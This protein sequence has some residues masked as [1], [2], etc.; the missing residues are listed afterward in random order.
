MNLAIW[1]E[2]IA[3]RYTD[4]EA[5]F[6]GTKCIGTYMDLWRVAC[7]L[8]RQLEKAGVKLG[9]RVAVLMHNCPEYL[10]AFYGVWSMGAVILPINSKLHSKEVK[11]IL[12][13]A[14]CSV[15]LTNELHAFELKSP[16]LTI[17]IPKWD[18]L[19]GKA[20]YSPITR[21]SDDLAWLFYTSGTTGRP[22]GVMITHGMIK[23]M[24][25]SY[26]TDVDQ[27][28]SND[29]ALY[30]APMSHGAGLY[31]VMH[32]LAGARHAMPLSG[33]FD[34]KEIF[35]LAKRLKSIHL[36]AA[37]TM[38]KRL[39]NFAKIN[40]L[41]GRGIRTIVYAGGPM[42]LLDII[43]ATEKFGP[44]FIQ[45][46]GQG[47]CPMGIT[48]LPRSKV[49]DR[50]SEKWKDRLQSVGFAQSGIEIK[51]GNKLGN[52][53]KNGEIG[54]IMVRGELVMPGYWDNEEATSKTIING[55]LMT[56]DMGTIDEDG[57]LTMHGRSND[58]IISGGSNIY[59]R[60]VEEV[61]LLHNSVHEVSIVGRNSDRWGEEVV[62]FVVI[63]KGCEFLPENLDKH[64]LMHI[65]R[66]K[67][68]KHYIKVNKLPKNN[69][70]KILKTK[71]RE[72][73]K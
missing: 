57:Y 9:D 11:W 65:A 55:W 13:N 17:L 49:A 27:I 22:K 31:S 48:V 40:D 18:N 10:V 23:K 60:E 12:K 73:L 71:L 33:G 72:K 43:E 24:V 2:R 26:F 5:V 56:G 45:V 62:A 19:L 38:V 1:L 34:E 47:E 37:P 53:K 42:Y 59:P 16:D 66:F 25:Q 7:S 8:R 30:A 28:F 46:Y 58:M 4:K 6:H 3:T 44:I 54:E 32:V 67:R 29:T 63:K 41:D 39:T 35:S 21:S 64:C 36:F 15:V 68:P 70:G 52:P 20:C 61:L 14:K 69:Y 51:I 50:K